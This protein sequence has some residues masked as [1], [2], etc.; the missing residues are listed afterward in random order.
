M[1]AVRTSETSVNNHF[2]RQY[3]PENNSENRLT[4]LM[5]VN[6]T[7]TDKKNT[8]FY[9]K[10]TNTRCFKNVKNLSA[11]YAA[12]KKAWMTSDIFQQRIKAKK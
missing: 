1:E 9:W 6:M 8:L 4:V 7:G 2:T 3:I 5:Y 10:I 12:N 11:E